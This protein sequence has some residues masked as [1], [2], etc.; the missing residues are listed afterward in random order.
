MN[1]MLSKVIKAL[2]KQL[3]QHGDMPCYTNS[4]YGFDSLTEL[5]YTTINVGPVGILL[6]KEYQNFL[7]IT[8]DRVICHIGGM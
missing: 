4:E 5:N 3:A 2:E 6:E 7:N 8:H 1:M